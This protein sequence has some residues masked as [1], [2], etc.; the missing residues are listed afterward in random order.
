MA[1]KL[2]WLSQSRL[3]EIECMT[4]KCLNQYW[5]V[6]LLNKLLRKRIKQVIAWLNYFL[7]ATEYLST[8]I[9]VLMTCEFLPRLTS[10]HVW[11]SFQPFSHSWASY[12][13]L[14]IAW[15]AVDWNGRWITS[16]AYEWR[17]TIE[18][19]I[20]ILAIIWCL[21]YFTSPKYILK[22]EKYQNYREIMFAM[23][24]FSRLS[25]KSLWRH[26]WTLFVAPKVSATIKSNLF[27]CF[28]IF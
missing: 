11:W 26:K 17:V 13:R 14:F 3:S 18:R 20:C 1:S 9:V 25:L 10:F 23:T 28:I 5:K 24:L 21:S 7:C 4:P 8:V 16:A 15:F 27:I 22:I 12:C 19:L 2:R 6:V